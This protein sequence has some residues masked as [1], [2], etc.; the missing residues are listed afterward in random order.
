[1]LST[2]GMDPGFPTGVKF[3]SKN[4]Q[5]LHEIKMIRVLGER[6]GSANVLRL[7]GIN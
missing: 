7:L 4:S 2:V 1:M 3:F 6:Q 5:K